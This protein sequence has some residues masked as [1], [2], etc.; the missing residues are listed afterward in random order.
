M[1]LNIIRVK[2]TDKKKFTL[3]TN[4]AGKIEYPCTK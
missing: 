4:G 3:S 1:N 2:N